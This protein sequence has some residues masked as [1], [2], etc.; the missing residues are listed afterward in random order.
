MGRV[1]RVGRA[2]RVGLIDGRTFG[3]T[4]RLKRNLSITY[5]T[6][7]PYQTSAYPLTLPYLPSTPSTMLPRP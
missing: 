4:I 2:G 1:R 5:Q 7:L 6:Y 3:P